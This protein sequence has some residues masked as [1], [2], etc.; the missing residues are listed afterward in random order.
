MTTRYGTS[1]NTVSNST[2]RTSGAPGTISA[3]LWFSVLLLALSCGQPVSVDTKPTAAQTMVDLASLTG[4][5]TFYASFDRG[6]D[7]DHGGGD[8][9]LYSGEFSGGKEQRPMP[10]VAGLGDPPLK[11]SAGRYGQALQFSPGATHTAFY[12]MRDNLSFDP[13][14]AQGTLSLWLRVDPDSIPGRYCDPIQL[15]DKYYASDCIFL[16]FTK[17]DIPPDFRLAVFGHQP[18][19]DPSDLEGRAEEF[20]FRLAK[21]SEPP[22]A[23]DR[24][25]H[26][27]ITWAA[28]NTGDIGRGR[29][30]LDGRLAGITGPVM[31]TLRWDMD[32][33]TLRLGVGNYIGSIDD[34]ALFDRALSETE[35]AAINALPEGIGALVAAE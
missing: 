22:F 15:T 24:W 11:L 1:A 10:N 25:T 34:I 5:L 19:W 18:E 31:E 3:M 28:V 16:D 13:L 20:F 32:Q 27:V 35:V 30:Y 29:L 6:P 9:T 2:Y 21:V 4:A 17:N 33:V 26:V 8:L 12:R 23:G 7:A 14:H